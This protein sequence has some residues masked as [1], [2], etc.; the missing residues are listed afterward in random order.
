MTTKD[1]SGFL[2]GETQDNYST[3]VLC[4]MF[5]LRVFVFLIC[6]QSDIKQKYQQQIQLEMCA[7]EMCAFEKENRV[8]EIH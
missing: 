4:L 3:Y 8:A 7:F 2:D 1:R 5:F 6:S